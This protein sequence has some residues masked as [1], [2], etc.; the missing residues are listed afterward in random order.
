MT[1]FKTGNGIQRLIRF[2]YRAEFITLVH[3]AKTA[4][5]LE[6]QPGNSNGG[7]G[8]ARAQPYPYPVPMER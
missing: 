3:K 2:G 7:G 8:T 5:G 6:A 1:M 4:A